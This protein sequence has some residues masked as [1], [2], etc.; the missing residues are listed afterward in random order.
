MFPKVEV[1]GKRFFAHLT[2]V[3]LLSAVDSFVYFKTPDLGK[4]FSALIAPERFFARVCSMG[5]TSIEFLLKLRNLLY[6]T[7]LTGKI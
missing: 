2:S 4:E 7:F 3:R 1:D 6:Y 5:K